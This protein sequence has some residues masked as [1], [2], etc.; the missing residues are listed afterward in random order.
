MNNDCCGRE[1]QNFVSEGVRVLSGP[2]SFGYLE[3]EECRVVPAHAP[4]ISE[5]SNMHIQRKTWICRRSRAQ[6]AEV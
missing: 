3:K 2:N 5:A 6:A 1:G 4:P